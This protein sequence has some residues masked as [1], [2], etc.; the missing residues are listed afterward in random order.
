LPFS[1][2][3]KAHPPPGIVLNARN[4]SSEGTKESKG[5]IIK[6]MHYYQVAE[7]QHHHQT[8]GES[9]KFIAL[10]TSAFTSF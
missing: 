2:Y 6:H 8:F 5:S 3:K 7:D 10:E 4:R 1:H 9:Q